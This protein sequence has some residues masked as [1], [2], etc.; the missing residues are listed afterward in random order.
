MGILGRLMGKA[1]QIDPAK[2]NEE[3]GPLLIEGEE[4]EAAFKLVRDTWVFT[5]KRLIMTDAQGITGK[6]R[7]YLTIPYSKIT[8]FSLESSGH[9][10]LDSDLKIWVGSDL[11]PIKQKITK[12]T[13]VAELYAT[14]STF[15]LQ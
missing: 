8:K 12:E 13:G 1:S 3:Y 7:D 10:D 9:F 4:V 6:K 15:I 14:L 2:V 11:E 5:N